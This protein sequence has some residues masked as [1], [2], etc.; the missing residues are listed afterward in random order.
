VLLGP[1]MIA[2]LLLAHN[3]IDDRQLAAAERFR[4]ARVRAVRLAPWDER[5][6][7]H[8][9]RRYSAMVARLTEDQHMALADVVLD[10]RPAWLRRQLAGLPLTAEDQ[11]ERRDL[12]EALDALI[13]DGPQGRPGRSQARARPPQCS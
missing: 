13:G 2:S 12:L 9:A 3:L 6:R 5:R 4:Q 8:P 11:V 7:G 1:T 10:Q